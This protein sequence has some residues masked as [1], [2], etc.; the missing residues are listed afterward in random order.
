MTVAPYIAAFGGSGSKDTPIEFYVPWSEEAH[1]AAF[2]DNGKD[3]N[4]GA[5]YC[6]FYFEAEE[7][8]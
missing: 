4:F 2:T 8:N 1:K 5:S 6:K 3:P 7:C